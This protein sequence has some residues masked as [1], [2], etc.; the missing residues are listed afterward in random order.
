MASFKVNK[1]EL[2]SLN[3]TVF[4]KLFLL[5]S[6]KEA[7]KYFKVFLA[8]SYDVYFNLLKNFN[9]KYKYKF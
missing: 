8:K 6:K 7:L 3:L 4:E 1:L 2:K 5:V 9:Y